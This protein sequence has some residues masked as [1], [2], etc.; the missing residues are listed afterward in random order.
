MGQFISIGELI[1]IS[2][3]SI[4]GYVLFKTIIEQFKKDVIYAPYLNLLKNASD[5]ARQLL[6]KIIWP[7][8]LKTR[9]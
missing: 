3:L 9:R 8:P 1:I 7:W 5:I 4:V 2:V 6:E